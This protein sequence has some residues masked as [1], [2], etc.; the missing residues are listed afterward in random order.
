MKKCCI[1]GCDNEMK[2]PGSGTCVN[3][4]ST[5]LRWSKRTAADIT[6]RAQTIGL[7]TARMQVLT[8]ANLT[9]MNPRKVKLKGMP[10]K[11]SRCKIT[12]KKKIGNGSR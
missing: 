11:L 8:P 12:L 3:C 4:Y 5:I 1:P 9:I 7:Y 2:C 10:G 6:K